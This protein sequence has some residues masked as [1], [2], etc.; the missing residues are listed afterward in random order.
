M[1]DSPLDAAFEAAVQGDPAGL[2]QLYDELA[3]AV[4]GYLRVRG[5]REPEDLCSEVFLAVFPRL[6]T[7]SGGAA[8]LRTLLFSIAHARLVDE[9]RRR[10]RRGETAALDELSDP[11]TARS[12][13]DEALA[14]YSSDAVRDILGQLPPD[15]RDVLL[16]RLVADLTVEQVAETMGKSPG[17]VKQLQ[18]RGLNTLR[19][20]FARSGVPL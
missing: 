6:S 9:L 11:R 8:G 3:P 4:A 1:P 20:R 13:E 12:A 10:S 14:A 17:A 19:A 18:R 5:A 15:Q 2:R 7:V 16:L